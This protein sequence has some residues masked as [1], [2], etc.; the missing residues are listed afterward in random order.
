MSLVIDASIAMAWC[1]ED[2]YTPVA[3]AV[4]ARV[5]QE[6]AVVP[7]LWGSEVTNVL[8]VAERRHRTTPADTS[9]FIA[10]LDSLPLEQADHEPSKEQ[11]AAL[12]RTHG[13]TAYDACYLATAMLHGYPLATLDGA[14]A[15]AATAAGVS[16]V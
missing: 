9:R 10:L 2:E 14:L 16:L 6:G 15:K 3:D 5:L 8:L 11:V 13:L 7:P 4:L 1:F 12:A